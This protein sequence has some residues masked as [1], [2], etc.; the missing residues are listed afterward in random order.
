MSNNC[1]LDKKDLASLPTVAAMHSAI[2]TEDIE[3]AKFQMGQKVKHPY[4]VG[5]ITAVH[6]GDMFEY[7]VTDYDYLLY[8]SELEP[9]THV[10]LH[11]GTTN[12][13][14]RYLCTQ[15]GGNKFD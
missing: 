2:Y 5:I 13:V 3:G 1:I 14:N 11:C 4:G 8:E 7:A 10:C 15:C 9:V 12:D 6:Y